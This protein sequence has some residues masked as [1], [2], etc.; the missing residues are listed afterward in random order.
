LGLLLGKTVSFSCTDLVDEKLSG[1]EGQRPRETLAALEAACQAR[2]LVEEGTVAYVFP[3]DLIHG[4]L[5]ADLSAARRAALHQ[6]MAEALAELPERLREGRAAELA[7]H[8]QEAGEAEQALPWALRAGKQAEAVYAHQDAE[9]HYQT[10]REL[11]HEL[12]DQRQEAV[13]RERLGAV[14]GHLARYRQ[15]QEQLEAAL[16]LYQALGEVEGQGH[17][18]A[19]LGQVYAVHGDA[20]TP[21]RG[22][23]WIMPRLA[24]LRASGLSLS[25]QAR[26][27]LVLAWLYVFTESFAE[28]LA[29]AER[30]VALAQQAHDDRLLYR[31]QM[32]R[33][34]M[35]LGRERQAEGMA[36]LREVIPLLEA[37]GDLEPLRIAQ[38]NLAWAYLLW[39]DFEH[40]WRT[41]ERAVELAEQVGDVQGIAIALVRQA[42]LAIYVG[43]WRQARLV[44][45]RA[46]S[47][48][49]HKRGLSYY[50]G[51]V[52]Y[53]QGVLALAEGQTETAPHLLHQA[54]DRIAEHEKAPLVLPIMVASALAEW[55]LL[56]GHAEAACA[57]LE[58]F[59]AGSGRFRLE[60]DVRL[61]MLPRLAQAYAEQGSIKQAETLLTDVL[62]QATAWR[63][64]FTVMEVRRTQGL[65]ALRQERWQ[66]A[67]Q[68]LEEALSLCQ[69]MRAPYEEA[70]T[71]YYFG[72]LHRA[73]GQPTEARE[74]W[75]T[76]LAILNRLGERLYAAQV[77]QGLAGLER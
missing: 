20:R 66:D 69:T 28:S 72:I 60:E 17:A 58:P 46:Q 39:G 33:G 71:R 55:E 9:R 74:S 40:A 54:L 29:A 32:R 11:A 49:E 73:R 77:E 42:E 13:A 37:S 6:Q 15:A 38:F 75:E 56:A 31:A 64:R 61:A 4:V 5:L 26:L 48:L 8:W 50:A 70:K 63:R 12:G 52:L 51:L 45:D 24:P 21:E 14:L 34:S 27:F 41:H 43:E 57:R 47:L 2:L 19:Q 35:L 59:R 30:A 3:H 23:A 10:A 68:A 76:A 25:G 22:I 67:V 16:A 1:P 7:W 62:T 18:L 53:H 36:A 65:L 44:C